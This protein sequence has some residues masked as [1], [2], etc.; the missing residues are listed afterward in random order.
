MDESHRHREGN[1]GDATRN[2]QAEEQARQPGEPCAADELDAQAWGEGSGVRV[3]C[4]RGA[5]SVWL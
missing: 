3:V 4:V 5:A 1:D 2:E